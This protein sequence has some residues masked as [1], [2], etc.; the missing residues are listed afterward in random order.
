MWKFLNPWATRR[1]VLDQ[2]VDRVD[3]PVADPAGAEID[4]PG[5]EVPA[6]RRGSGTWDS[7]RVTVQS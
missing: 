1:S 6:R 3:G 7:I 2:Q 4:P 5:G